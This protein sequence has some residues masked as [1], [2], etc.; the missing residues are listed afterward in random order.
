MLLMSQP[1]ERMR[2]S[3]RFGS[4]HRVFVVVKVSDIL[5]TCPYFNSILNLTFL[6]QVVLRTALS[7]LLPLHLGFE[8]F[9]TSL[10][11]IGFPKIKVSH[12]MCGP[13]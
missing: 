5:T 11:Y 2:P 10:R 9:K 6:M 1:V 3:R 12:S 8:H 7:R 4:A 13:H